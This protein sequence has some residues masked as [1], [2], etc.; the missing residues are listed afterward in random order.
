MLIGISINKKQKAP[1]KK[2]TV[3]QQRICVE[4]DLGGF[5]FLKT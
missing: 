4:T 3:E 2:E 5:I 1:N